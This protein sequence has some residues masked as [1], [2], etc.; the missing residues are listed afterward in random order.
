MTEV[1]VMETGNQKTPASAKLPSDHHIHHSGFMGHVPF[2]SPNKQ[3]QSAEGKQLTSS[4]SDAMT[5]D[6]W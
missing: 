2:L 4:G 6:T 5:L 3:C 1:A